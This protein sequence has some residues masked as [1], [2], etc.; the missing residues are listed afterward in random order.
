MLY[1]CMEN[2]WLG[3]HFWWSKD[4]VEGQKEYA[5]IVQGVNPT[6]TPA[7]TDS[8]EYVAYCGETMFAYHYPGGPEP[9][10]GYPADVAKSGREICPVCAKQTDGP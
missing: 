1:T 2:D 9:V 10:F 4:R 8:Q 5:H 6:E 3:T 7:G